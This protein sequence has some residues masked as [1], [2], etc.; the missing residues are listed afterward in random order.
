MQRGEHRLR[1]VT[2]PEQTVQYSSADTQ[3]ILNKWME[4]RKPQYKFLNS[5]GLNPVFSSAKI[6]KSRIMALSKFPRGFV[7]GTDQ[8]PWPTQVSRQGKARG[9]SNFHT[10]W[11]SFCYY[12][13]LLYTYQRIWLLYSNANNCQD[14]NFPQ[15]NKQITMA[16]SHKSDDPNTFLKN[17]FN[18]KLLKYFFFRAQ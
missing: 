9:S 8:V 1:E 12:C 18:S 10:S 11:Q 2:G 7:P 3:Q 17:N 4:W 6:T 14:Y 16:G 13:L 15:Q 5:Y